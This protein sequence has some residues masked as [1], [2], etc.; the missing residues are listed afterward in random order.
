MMFKAQDTLGCV[1]C[2]VTILLLEVSAGA[3]RPA[4]CGHP[5]QAVRPTPCSAWSP[6]GVGTGTSAGSCYVDKPRGLVVRCTRSGSG[7]I[8]CDNEPMTPLPHWPEFE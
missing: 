7:V 4:C 1:V 2:D 3:V 5:M 8:S 6:R